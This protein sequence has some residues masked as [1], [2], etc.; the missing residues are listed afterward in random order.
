MLVATGADINV[1]DQDGCNAM[2]WA[3]EDSRAPMAVIETLQSHRMDFDTEDVDGM[4]VLAKAAMHGP[5]AVLQKILDMCGF[6]IDHTDHRGCTAVHW[7][8][9]K[10]LPLL[11]ER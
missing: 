10:T 8:S 6:D 2:H 9:Q 1:T 7:S 5:V 3:V 4:S 11:I